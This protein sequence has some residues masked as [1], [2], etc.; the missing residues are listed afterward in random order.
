M[1]KL[2]NTKTWYPRSGII[3]MPMWI[4]SALNQFALLTW[5]WFCRHEECKSCGSNGGF[6]TDFIRRS[7][8]A[9]KNM[10]ESQS[11]PQAP[12]MLMHEAMKVKPE[13]QW[14]PQEFRDARNKKYLPMKASV[15]VWTQ[16]KR[17]AMWTATSNDIHKCRVS[18]TLW[19]LRLTKI[20]H[21]YHTWSCET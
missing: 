15:R 9:D 16:S 10:T 1:D 18:L 12:E 20:C 6:H 13:L 5:Y 8:K 3:A 7:R 2:T 19:N 21:G 17:E 4:G 11:L 14:R